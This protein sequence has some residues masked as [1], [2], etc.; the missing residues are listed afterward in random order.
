M[1]C[2]PQPKLTC[3]QQ[4]NIATITELTGCVSFSANSH[5]LLIHLSCLLILTNRHVVASAKALGKVDRRKT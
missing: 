5:L 1:P 4:N 2:K 3:S